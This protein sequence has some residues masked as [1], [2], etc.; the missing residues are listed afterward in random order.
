MS[1]FKRNNSRAANGSGGQPVLSI[2][3]ASDVHGSEVCWRKF[4][5]AARFYGVDALV[6]GGDLTGKAVVPIAQDDGRY[7]ALFLG[8]ERT[9]QSAE[10]LAELVD[11]VRYN[12]MYPWVA[13]AGEI[14]E[15]ANDDARR[16]ALFDKVMLDELRR[17]IEL[18][19][20]KMSGRGVGIYVMVVR[21][22]DRLGPRGGGLRRAGCS[23][24]RPRDDLVLVREPNPVEQPA[25]VARGRAVREARAA[26][27]PA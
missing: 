1:L 18:A 16:A 21:R 26:G 20:E 2:Y 9:A 15:A 23:P 17:W 7:T 8:Q 19:D 13:T 6:M 11:A 5:G 3:Y 27:Q 22:R 10:E 12:G 24:R 4:L 14:D 25:R